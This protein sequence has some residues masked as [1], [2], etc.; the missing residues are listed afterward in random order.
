MKCFYHHDADAVGSCKHCH[1]GICREC[2]AERDG[3]LSCKGRCESQVDLV[4]ALINRNIHVGLKARPLSL[5]ALG[6]FVV[7]FFALLYLAVT[8]SNDSVRTMLYLL[9]AFSFVGALGQA[10]ILRTW[11]ARRAAQKR[12]LGS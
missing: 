1:R 12:Q 5:V 9:S 2:A 6:V 8:E 4:S 10:S 7:A 11:L 3:G